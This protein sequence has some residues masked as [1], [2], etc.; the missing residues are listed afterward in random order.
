MP[1]ED[2]TPTTAEIA[3]AAAALKAKAAQQTAVL[4]QAA[5]ISKA[6]AEALADASGLAQSAQAVGL[7][8]GAP[9][10]GA[11]A[12]TLEGLDGLDVA[13]LLQGLA[14]LDTILNA[15]IPNSDGRTV[16]AALLRFAIASR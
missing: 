10:D 4:S 6:L 1:N 2:G 15:E 16:R 9:V 3:A 13:G 8:T 11:L 5:A 12:G 14:G 7:T